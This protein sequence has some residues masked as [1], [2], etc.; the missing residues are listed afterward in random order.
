MGSAAC[1]GDN[2]MQAAVISNE[3]KLNGVFRMVIALFP[4]K[5]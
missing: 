1:T 5:A 2:A 4:L 3:N